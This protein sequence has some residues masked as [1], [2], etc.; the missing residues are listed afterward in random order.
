M[1]EHGLYKLYRNIVMYTKTVCKINWWY[2]DINKL[3]CLWT[4]SHFGDN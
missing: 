3:A 4:F 1:N 2:P